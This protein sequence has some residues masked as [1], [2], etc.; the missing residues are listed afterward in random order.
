MP[1]SLLL[2][3][4]PA[5]SG[6]SRVVREM[7]DSREVDIAVDMTA[8]WAAIRGIE[9]NPETGR[10]P[11]RDDEDPAPPV[12]QYLMTVAVRQ[13]LTNGLRTVVTSGS[14]D[15]AAYWA[16]IATGHNASF[17]VRSEDPGE[18]VVRERLAAFG[19]SPETL[20]PQCERAVRRWYV[21]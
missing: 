13:A 15:R 8:L 16:G 20:T 7:L 6:K 9:R 14:P 18:S 10:Y 19:G 17:H 1:A 11:I 21:A 2:I 12:V 4:G 5:G 3:E